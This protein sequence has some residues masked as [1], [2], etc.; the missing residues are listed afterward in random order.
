MILQNPYHFRSLKYFNNKE[1]ITSIN[2][3]LAI[4][5]V[6]LKSKE[7]L[8]SIQLAH[9][10][11]TLNPVFITGLG[12][13][14]K[15]IPSFFHPLIS[16]DNNWIALDLRPFVKLSEDQN[17]YIVK[18]QSEYDLNVSRMI[19]TGMWYLGKQ[20][21]IYGF[22]FPHIAFSTWLS[23]NLARKF[24]LDMVTE[25][26]IKVLAFIYYSRLS[27]NSYTED[28]MTK[29]IIRA[30]EDSF[31]PDIVK[32][33]YQQVTDLEDVDDFCKACYTVTQNVRLKGLDY[34]G[35][36]N[37]LSNNW[38]GSEGKQ[39]VLLATEHPPTWISLVHAALTQKAFQ[40]NY[41]TTLID[42]LNKKGKGED[43][44]KEYS[45]AV[46]QFKD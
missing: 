39:L 13:S 1:I 32:E 11:K 27:T 20:S 14:S 19:L 5:Y 25:L 4:D 46:H 6:Y 18:N 45:N 44:L 8:N 36:I 42:K 34:I 38:I 43:F 3:F 26:K 40:R 30:K 35:L 21:T 29:L 22:T 37:V 33:I 24:G 41:I 17:S 9:L 16:E 10:G 15:D 2:R 31:M 28:D 7:K 12:E 23:D